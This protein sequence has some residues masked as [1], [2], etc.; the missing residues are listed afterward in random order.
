MLSP[1]TGRFGLTT[2]CRES[3]NLAEMEHS[4]EEMIRI[5]VSDLC[6]SAYKQDVQLLVGSESWYKDSL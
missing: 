3:Q 1:F 4:H 6:G 5:I 2:D